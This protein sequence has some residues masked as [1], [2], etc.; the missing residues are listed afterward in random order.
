MDL[1]DEVASMSNED[2]LDELVWAYKDMKDYVDRSD[3]VKWSLDAEEKATNKYW[4][5]RAE[6]INRMDKEH[7]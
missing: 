2:L 7:P 6:A 4:Y 3:W 5:L 1:K